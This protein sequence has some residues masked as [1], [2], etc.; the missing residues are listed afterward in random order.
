MPRDS[1]ETSSTFKYRGR[2][3]ESVSRR[4]KQ[5]SGA[6]DGFLPPEIISF[7]PREG[8]NCIRIL[9][10]LS[11][12][13]PDANA[14]AE[15]WG[16]HWG[17]DIFLHFN[18]GPDNASY[19]CLDKMKG[20]PC[21]VC[22]VRREANEEEADALKLSNRILCWVV[23]RSDEKSGPKLW[24]M[25]LGTSKDISAA[26]Q[27]KGSGE[28]L[29]ID[30]PEEGFDVYFD[31]EGEKIKTKYKRVEVGRDPCP[32][33]TDPKVQ[34]RWLAYVDEMMLP[35][36]LVYYPYDHIKKVL[37]GQG[38]SSE[39]RE[40]MRGNDDR[41]PPRRREDEQAAEREEQPNRSR[42]FGRA[43]EEKE[44]VG[45][46]TSRF[47][48]NAE[49]SENEDE[50]PLGRER[51]RS[52][53]APHAERIQRRRPGEDAGNPVD[54]E[55]RRRDPAARNDGPDSGDDSSRTVAAAKDRL[56]RL[57]QRTGKSLASRKDPDEDIPY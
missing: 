49:S 23:D 1:K 17:I 15:K 46:G 28:V 40:Y 42:R 2:T 12:S 43:S 33:H 3:E 19:L 4:A 5:S 10:W 25:P 16:D 18:V 14:Y 24:S 41:Q 29:L 56:S 11:G 50:R 36:I 55:P 31:R 53:E 26:S 57:G 35:D 8:E 51:R 47:S 37:F 38:V 20:E 13:H 54:D 21:P 39:E 52:E 32:L 30:D 6:Y 48:R 22:E 9:P 34:A 7:K 44:P 45:T 27:V